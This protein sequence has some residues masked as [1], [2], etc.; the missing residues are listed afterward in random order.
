MLLRRVAVALLA[1]VAPVV[2][3]AVPA[4]AATYPPGPPTQQTTVAPGVLYGGSADGAVTFS[5]CNGKT[6]ANVQEGQPFMLKVC[7]FLPGGQVRAYVRPAH[8]KRYFVDAVAADGNGSVVVGPFR[9]TA[10][11][12]YAFSFTGVKGNL[13]GLGVGGVGSRGMSRVFADPTRTVNM[14]MTVPTAGDSALP[15][16]GGDS[17]GHSAAGWGIGLVLG[18]LLLVVVAWIRRRSIHSHSANA[19]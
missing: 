8:H 9:L 10:P 3:A 11:G 5:A 16:T 6:A 13:S 2:I 4:S 1:I 14:A 19:A 17:G 18:G 7:G 15:R 12:R